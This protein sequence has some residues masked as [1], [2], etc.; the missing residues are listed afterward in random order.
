ML[1]RDQPTVPGTTTPSAKI[2]I[3]A[4]AVTPCIEAVSV[5]CPGASAVSVGAL[6][7]VIVARVPSL[8]LQTASF[9]G[10]PRFVTTV[11]CLLSPTCMVAVDGVTCREFG[12]GSVGAYNSAVG[13]PEPSRP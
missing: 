2:V 9:L 5:T 1:G 13:T 10:E 4:C 6:S 7:D 8:T 11:N 12:G 3:S